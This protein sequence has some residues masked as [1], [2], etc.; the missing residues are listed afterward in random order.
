MPPPAPGGAKTHAAAALIRA[1]L[2]DDR[3]AG[4]LI[5]EQNGGE[6]AGSSADELTRLLIDTAAL[7][8]VILLKACGYD[9]RKAL[10]AMDGWM[11]QA[12]KREQP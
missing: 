4:I 9:V 7:A 11:D 5:I 12:A 1:V 3:S 10:A 8:Q 6:K 2:V